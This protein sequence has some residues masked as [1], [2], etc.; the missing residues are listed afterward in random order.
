MIIG[1]GGIRNKRLGKWVWALSAEEGLTV[2]LVQSAQRDRTPLGGNLKRRYEAMLVKQRKLLAR[3][4]TG[5]GAG[6]DDDGLKAP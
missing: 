5:G 1:D 4:K 2:V 3:G 6:P